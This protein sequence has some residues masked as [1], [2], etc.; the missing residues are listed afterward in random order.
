[1]FAASLTQRLAVASLLCAAIIA[2]A[3]WAAA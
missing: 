1:M 3:L 2:L